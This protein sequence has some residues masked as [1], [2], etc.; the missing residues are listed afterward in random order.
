MTRAERTDSG[1][2]LTD[3]EREAVASLV[4]AVVNDD[5]GF[6]TYGLSATERAAVRRGLRKLL[7]GCPL[8]S[9]G[10][11][12]TPRDSYP[13]LYGLADVAQAL[14]VRPSNVRTT[15]GAAECEY[16]GGRVAATPLYLADAIDALA[17]E[18]RQR[19]QYIAAHRGD[20]GA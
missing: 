4:A 1:V 8:M 17:V 5:A 19:P 2:R 14:G 3:A 20:P 10:S 9:Q 15:P 11:S 6:E 7:R 13:R 12:F 18:R 16:P